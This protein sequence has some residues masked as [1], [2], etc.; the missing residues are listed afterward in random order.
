M[1][2][3]PGIRFD[4]LAL[5]QG[6]NRAGF[7]YDQAQLMARALA[8]NFCIFPFDTLRLATE[9]EAAG[10]TWDEARHFTRAIANAIQVD[11]PQDA[12]LEA[13]G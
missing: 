6:L 7:Q 11:T 10:L 13:L 5:A 4:T 9:L 1:D 3:M 8:D 2:P 12:G